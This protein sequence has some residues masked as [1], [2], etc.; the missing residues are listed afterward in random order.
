MHSY[1]N[2]PALFVVGLLIIIGES[3]VN[4]T[5]I[6]WSGLPVVLSI[7]LPFRRYFP[8]SFVCVTE[9]TK[10][11]GL[12]FVH[13]FLKMTW[14]YD[15]VILRPPFS[16]YPL[17]DFSFLVTCFPGT[18]GSNDSTFSGYC[19]LCFIVALCLGGLVGAI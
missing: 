18:L 1:V 16:A 17:S 15:L 6:P 7:G 4:N 10:F 13:H 3:A 12:V 9:S 2:M 14:Q 8:L 19:S 5:F 11:H